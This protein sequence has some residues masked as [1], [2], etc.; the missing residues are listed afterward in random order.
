MYYVLSSFR[1]EKAEGQSLMETYIINLNANVCCACRNSNSRRAN[2]PKSKLI[3]N[4][5]AKFEYGPV[6]M[7]FHAE[8]L[9]F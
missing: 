4:H 6:K 9:W 8:Y 3:H 1:E 5:D 2:V 7:F